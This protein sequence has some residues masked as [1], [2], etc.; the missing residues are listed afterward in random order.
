MPARRHADA[1]LDASLVQRAAVALVDAVA[2]EEL[3]H[4]RL[5]LLQ[6]ARRAG[7]G[8]DLPESLGN[9]AVSELGKPPVGKGLD[10][11]EDLGAILTDLIRLDGGP[12]AARQEIAAGQAPLP[13]A[14]DDED[15]NDRNAERREQAMNA[16]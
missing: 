16:A 7:G 2:L 3:R 8:D 4:Q 6:R 10:A 11:P 9:H 12:M 13:E 5:A 15:E 14:E 1:R